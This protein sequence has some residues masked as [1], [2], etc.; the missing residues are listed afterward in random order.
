MH[1]LR[2][3]DRAHL[4]AGGWLAGVDEAGRGALAG[5]VVAAAVFLRAD[6]F[7]GAARRS[8][9]RAVN[10]SK[11]LT[12]AQREDLFAVLA[13]AQAEGVLA[14]AAGIGAVEE[15]ECANIL[16]ATRRAMRRALETGCPED[17][18]LPAAGGEEE[19][20]LFASAPAPA[21][22]PGR[23]LVDGR[24]LRPFPYRHDGIV[25]GDG[26][27]LAIALAS[28]WAKVTRDRLMRE[29][30]ATYPEFGFDV[31]KGYGT[32]AHRAAILAHGASP[33]HRSLFLRKLR[34]TERRLPPT[35]S[36]ELFALERRS[37][38]LTASALAASHVG[39]Q[40]TP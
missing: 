10:D 38:T 13:A 1:A 36:P 30:G 21:P 28:I 19:G 24:P 32:A 39:V 37:S 29:L 33:V 16:G 11:Q 18:A 9:W 2:R 7:R 8:C 25:Q 34:E 20:S 12:A 6:F 3:F 31:H 23:I 5:P 15:I 17:C 35:P 14:V 22:R 40:K 27:S 4:P 26:K